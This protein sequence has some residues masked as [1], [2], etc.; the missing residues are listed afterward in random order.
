VTTA[1]V[2][3]KAPPPGEMAVF[4]F[5]AGKL[6]VANIVISVTPEY[7]IRAMVTN[8]VSPFEIT[9]QSLTLWGIPADP[10]H[11]AQRGREFVCN[12]RP[13]EEQECRGGGQSAG[14]NPIPFLVNPG[15]CT[16]TPLAANLRVE[17]WA[18]AEPS[19]SEAKVGPFTGCE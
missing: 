7:R 16:A 8:V 11:D 13:G 18:S 4:G 3:N 1:P 5:I 15:Q 6:I 10:S 17:S 2:F 19:L 14:Q 12:Q 9:R